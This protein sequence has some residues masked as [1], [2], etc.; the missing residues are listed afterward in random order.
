[1]DLAAQGEDETMGKISV[2]TSQLP[3]VI[4]DIEGAYSEEQAIAFTHDM[5]SVLEQRQRIV[6]VTDASNSGMTSLKTRSILKKFVGDSM[7]LS[8]ICTT[9]A[10]VVVKSNLV[11]MGVSAM[12]HLKKKKFPLQVFKSREE[13]IAWAHHQMKLDRGT[14]APDAKPPEGEELYCG[15]AE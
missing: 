14:A 7:H 15:D 10:A 5:R 8:D 2:D 6:V 9:A 12:F 4:I 3:V 13:A 1:M 11:R